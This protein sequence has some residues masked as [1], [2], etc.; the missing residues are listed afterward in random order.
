MNYLIHF[1][2]SAMVTLK[3]LEVAEVVYMMIDTL[4]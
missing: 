4:F 1:G 2:V 3:V